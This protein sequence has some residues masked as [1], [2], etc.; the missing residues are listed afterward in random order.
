MSDLVRPSASSINTQV[1]NRL[2]TSGA[3][4]FFSACQFGMDRVDEL[5]E[6]GFIGQS[7]LHPSA[8]MQN[9]GVVTASEVG[10]DIRVD[11][12]GQ[13]PG[14]QHG[15]LSWD[16]DVLCPAVFA[17]PS[18]RDAEVACHDASDLWQPWRFGCH[19]IGDGR[20][21]HRRIDDPAADSGKRFQLAE[22]GEQ[23]AWRAGDL[24][25]EYFGGI[26][27]QRHL[28]SRCEMFDQLQP[29]GGSRSADRDH[30][31]TP[32]SADQFPIE[33]VQSAR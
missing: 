26:G 5:P 32:A 17:Q 27:G 7:L 9:G 16:D 23:I 3:V 4:W 1:I 8:G 2:F 25:R 10:G 12:L 6:F 28:V 21:D 33:P 13:F 18:R 30:N 22:C 20:L 29:A 19:I 14:E 11:G 24:P 15:G 31:P